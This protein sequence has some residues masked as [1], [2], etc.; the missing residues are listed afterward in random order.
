MKKCKEIAITDYITIIKHSWTWAR[1]TDSEREQFIRVA[2]DFDLRGDYNTRHNTLQG[3]Y[4]A[5][6]TALDYNPTTW[7]ET[8]TERATNPRF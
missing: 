1:L 6:L 5:F 4:L 3:M 7:R 2:C 8:E